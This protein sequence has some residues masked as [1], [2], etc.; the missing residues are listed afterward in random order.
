MRRVEREFVVSTCA[1]PVFGQI[2]QC[3]PH[4]P[5]LERRINA[6]L[7]NAGHGRPMVP[8]AFGGGIGSI[9][10]DRPDQPTGAD[11]HVTF[12]L[13][14]PRTGHGHGLI[15]AGAVQ[16][17]PRQAAERAVKQRGELVERITVAETTQ[18][19]HAWT[20]FALHS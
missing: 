20:G 9:Q 10:L 6:E 16:S 12:T 1:C 19:D 5:V 13:I 11:C 8:S 7:V 18:G 17:H 15:N 2:Q 3:R 14:D 4:A